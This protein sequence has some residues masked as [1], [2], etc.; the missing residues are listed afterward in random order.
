MIGVKDKRVST[1]PSQLKEWK[2]K[3]KTILKDKCEVC[4]ST[5]VLILH[6]LERS[7]SYHS[8]RMLVIR[9]IVNQHIEQKEVPMKKYVHCPKCDNRVFRK[10]V[11]KK[12]SFVCK[13][14][15]AEFDN[16][17]EGVEIDKRALY[18]FVTHEYRH[19]IYQTAYKLAGEQFKEYM[20][21]SGTITICK[22]CH[23]KIHKGWLKIWRI[24]TGV[25]FIGY[26]QPLLNNLIQ[27]MING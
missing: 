13:R 11:E 12:P 9:D 8:L 24:G 18:Q 15:K 23:F 16:P 21:L 19:E 7:L 22:S 5:N 6:H 20:T 3:R 4:G 17:M 27:F 10:R 14:C 25:L 1:T 26:K 2:D